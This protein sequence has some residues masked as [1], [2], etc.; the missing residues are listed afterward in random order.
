[1]RKILVLACALALTGCAWMGFGDDSAT[2][3]ASEPGS[4]ASETAAEASEAAAET[5]AEPQETKPAKSEAKTPPTTTKGAKSEAQIREE[6]DA[7]GKKLASQASRTRM[8]N[9]ANPEYRQSGG[10]WIARYIEINP[11]SVRTSM[12]PGTSK[13]LYTGRVSYQEKVIECKGATKA[14]ALGG[15]CTQVK[16]SNVTELIRYD[17]KAWLD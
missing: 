1:M 9:K 13:G 6:L 3:S 5:A 15:T 4:E 14:A 11:G 10:M 7:T 16:A 2:V 17:G 8:P 12:A